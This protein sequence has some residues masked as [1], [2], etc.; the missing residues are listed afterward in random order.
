GQAVRYRSQPRLCERHAPGRRRRHLRRVAEQQGPHGKPRRRRPVGADPGRFPETPAMSAVLQPDDVA[1]VLRW[2]VDNGLD[3][4]I[5]AVAP[6][7]SAP[8]PP[9][10]PPA[11]AGATPAPV[12]AP[13]Q[14][15]PSAGPVGSAPRAAAP[16]PPVPL[17]SPQL[18]EDARELARRC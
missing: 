2:Y 13:V 14:R 10:P 8:P 9:P 7:P 15:P 17:E 3:E 11:A 6:D 16:R 12:P 1:A 5:G 18:V 4:P